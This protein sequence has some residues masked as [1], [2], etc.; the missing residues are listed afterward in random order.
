MG[1]CVHHD[2]DEGRRRFEELLANR[3]PV[4]SAQIDQVERGLLHLEMAT[5]ARATCAAIDSGNLQ[6]VRAHLTFID[7]LFH[8]ASPDLENAIYVSYL[9]NVFLGRDEERYRA[10]RSSLS[11]LLQS[12]LADLEDNWKRIAEWNRKR[13]SEP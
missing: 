3:F 7:E 9:E 12:A 13:L 11:G 5:F 4:I 6:E 2:G 10:A 8:N 1:G